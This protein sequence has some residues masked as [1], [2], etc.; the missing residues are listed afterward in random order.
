MSA[1]LM[2]TSLP[3]VQHFPKK[4][5]TLLVLIVLWCVFLWSAF[6]A[7]RSFSLYMDNEFF[8]GAVLS[9]MSATLSNGEWPLRMDTILGGVPL[10]NFS[11]LSPFYPLYLSALPIYNSPLD[12]IHT[13]H[14]ISLAHILIYEINMYIFLRVIGVSRLAALTGAALVA[15]SANSFGYAS[16]MNI[17]APYSWFPLYLA[18]L[19]GILKCPR[20]MLYSGM[21]LGGIVL[22]TLASPAQPLIHAIFVS[23][24]FIYAYWRHQ[25]RI[26]ETR[27]VLYALGCILAVGALALL[28]VAPV[29]LPAALE[30][31]NMI[32]WIGPFPAVMGNARIPF[33]A[34][35][36]DQLAIADLGGV[37]FKFKGAAVG[38][39]F[40]GV[41]AIALAS[42]AVVS[43]P[44]SWIVIALAF[45]ALYSLISSTGSN[46]G[47]AYINYVI[48]LL[49]KIREPSRFLVLLQF[50]I[51]VLAAFGIDE[52]RKTVSRIDGQID[53]KRQLMTL[54]MTAVI[55]VV[56]LLS[57]R[58][59]IV[60]SV[61][62]FVSVA[63]LLTLTLMTW[64]A[65]RS[66]LRSGPTM[67]AAVWGGAALT[68][69][70]IEVPW[71]PPSV[72]GSQYLTSGALALDKAIERV[73]AR[74][75]NH[76]Y[77]VV[78]DGKIDKQLAA[79]LASYRGVR[80]FNAYFN[81][82]PRRQ[83]EELYFHG[84]RAD[85]YFRILGAK[86]LICSEC[87][88]DSLNGYK[89]LESMAGYEIYETEDVLP[90]SYIVQRLNGE[91]QDLADFVTKAASVDLRSLLLFVQPNVVV[92]L[93]E[94]TDA[95]VNPCIK[96]EDIRTANRARF[97]VQC[98][99]SGVLVMN[100]FFDDAWKTRVDGVEVQA[101]KVNANQIGVPFPRG[102]HVIEFRYLPTIVMV[103]FG[104]AVIGLIILLYLAVRRRVLV[105]T[106]RHE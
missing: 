101:L 48:P 88:A 64:I 39:Q 90:H 10:Y 33:E 34:F 54:V 40:C 23:L 96:S 85:N 31:K 78:F 75:P 11:Q 106:N 73:S 52:L 45:I 72:S 36:F 74:D 66:K 51:G 13:L 62:P 63:I 80:T 21:A 57:L 68:L 20:S 105:Q 24:V 81:P 59:R 16:W 15:F 91:F 2:Q 17:V 42:V 95:A 102:S 1:E 43:R 26:G 4:V 56:V 30:F 6:G 46:L 29:L 67:I 49:N 70:A 32:R 5:L 98:Q 8:I 19:V 61:P 71:I 3:S 82:A 65:A 93:D 37:F 22:L 92:G 97:V 84:P 94:K 12:V 76:E 14:W 83:F 100:E 35:Q 103:S 25:S 99:S 44:R 53:T 89:H 69:L 77:R 7:D 104:I 27:Q 50:S 28:L 38:N 41:L 60:S 18:G 55:A 87:A 79:M 86:Y 58:D 9:S 47:L